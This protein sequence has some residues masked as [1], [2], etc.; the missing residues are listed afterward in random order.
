MQILHSGWKRS[1]VY[2][3]ERERGEEGEEEV[4]RGGETKEFIPCGGHMHTALFRWE[5]GAPTS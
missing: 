1:D 3:A 2:W 5:K 4:E